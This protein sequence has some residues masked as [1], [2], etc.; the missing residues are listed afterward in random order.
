LGLSERLTGVEQ[1]DS[2]RVGE[3]HEHRRERLEFSAID[4]GCD[5]RMETSS[6]PVFCLA[7]SCS[8]LTKYSRPAFSGAQVDTMPWCSHIACAEI[9]S[10]WC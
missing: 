2:G 6:T 4:A 8:I 5:R 10:S 3:G 9:Q 7:S 1:C